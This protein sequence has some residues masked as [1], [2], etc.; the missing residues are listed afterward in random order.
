MAETGIF[1]WRWSRRPAPRLLPH[2]HCEPTG[3]REARP[4]EAARSSPALL[5]GKILD[6]F[7]TLAMTGRWS[8]AAWQRGTLTRRA[9]QWQNGNIE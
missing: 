6:C 5:R 8:W 2:R 7:A 9:K 1:A 4:D 3:S